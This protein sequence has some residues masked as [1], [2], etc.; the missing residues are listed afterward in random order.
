M[1]DIHA[2]VLP[3]LDDGAESWDDALTMARLAVKS[4]VTDLIAT[5]HCGLPGQDPEGRAE[6]VRDQVYVFREK[7][8]RAEIP[9]NVY[10]GMEVFGTEDTDY[11][12]QK[13]LLTGLNGTRY[14]LIEF[15][16]EQYARPATRILDEVLSL[17]FCPVVGHPERY[18]YIQNDPT[19]LNLWMDMGCLF[20]VN[21]GSLMG[22]FGVAAQELSW[23]MLERGFICAVASDAHSPLMRTTWMKDVYDLL[24]DETSEDA[25][26]L[27]LEERPRQLLLGQTV[28]I[29]EPNWF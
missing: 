21:R 16:F 15:P 26:R 22:R 10:E 17:G 9:L 1:I 28:D 13:G 11:L 14:L 27:I 24:R 25:A 19:I 7:L 8:T 5:P 6:Q 20:Q 3:G 2:H 18:L 4:G 29:P 23:A 12:L